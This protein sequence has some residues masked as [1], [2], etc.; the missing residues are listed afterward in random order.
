LR[1]IGY[2]LS[3]CNQNRVSFVV[4]EDAEVYVNGYY[5]IN[6]PLSPVGEFNPVL[7]R[8]HKIT[9]YNPEMTVGSFGPIAGKKGEKAYYGKKLE[10]LV[11][12]AEVLGY[13]SW[14]GK[15]RRLECSPNTWDSVYE[16]NQEELKGFFLKLSGRRLI[17]RTDFPVKIGR[18][19]GLDMPFYLDLNAIAKGHMFVAG[20][21]VEYNEPLIY[22]D[23]GRIRIE[24]IG[25]FVDRFFSDDSAEGSVRVDDIYVPSFDPETYEI[26]WKPVTEVIRHEYHSSLVKLTVETGRSITVTPDHSVFVLR[27]CR[28]LTV[29]ASEIKVGDYLVI[30]SKIPPAQHPIS[31]I[32]VSEILLKAGYEKGIYL[33][34][35]P[36]NVY[37]RFDSEGLWSREDV[38][39]RLSWRRKGILPLRYARFLT[40]EEK[41]KTVLTARRGIEFSTIIKLDGGFARLLGYYVAEGSAII[42]DERGYRV[43]FD[44]GYDDVDIVEDIRGIIG[45]LASKDRIK[46]L[47]KHSSYRVIVCDKVLAVLLKSLV[48]GRA[49]D[50]RVP[51]VILN[52]SPDVIM[53]FLKAWFAGDSGVTTS[54]W[55]ASDIQYLFLTRGVLASFYNQKVENGVLPGGRRYRSASWYSLKFPFPDLTKSERRFDNP[56]LIPV[57]CLPDILK[58]FS[59][60]SSRCRVTKKVLRRIN[61]LARYLKLVLEGKVQIKSET[62]TDGFYR[63]LQG[64]G[65][66]EKRDNLLVLTGKGHMLLEAINKLN[67]L[68]EGDLSFLRVTRIER[69][70]SNHKFVYDLSVPGCENFVAG[71]GGVFCHN[72]RSGKSTFVLNLMARSLEQEPKPRFIVFDRR[73]EYSLLTKYGAVMLPYFRFVPR[74]ELVS[75]ELVASRLG[76]DPRR[77]DGRLLCEALN[78][79]RAEGLELTVKNVLRKC[80]EI[81]PYLLSRGRD[82]VLAK[83][84]WV[85]DKRGSQLFGIE[86]KPL[87]IIDTVYRN[88]AVIVDFSVDANIED[89]QL[90]AKY[91]IRNV[92]HYAVEHRR[93]GDFAVIF[94]IEEAQ[95][96]I[97]ERGLKIEVGSPEKTGVDKQIIEAISQAGGYNVGFILVTQRPAYV[98]KS[99]ISQCNTI[100]AFRL[101]AGNDQEAIIKYS[102]YGSER[103]ADYL[104]GL[105][106]HEAL[107]WGMASPVPFPVTVEVDVRD[108][109]AKTSVVA[110]VAWERMGLVGRSTEDEVKEVA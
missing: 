98:S 11:A 51:W 65:F 38:P 37:E 102:E 71:F 45:R 54:K 95:Y 32:D 42:N 50:K 92:M 20:M 72:T 44:L 85:L 107:I 4:M 7:L 29:P 53:E 63:F 28:I 17:D 109:P 82:S 2:V 31:E 87:N 93:A 84:R 68:F 108:Y 89:Q 110:K 103:M 66:I 52:S 36:D 13:I 9:P 27:D 30:P 101:M 106:D 49:R 1:Q 55:L 34:N 69:V 58:N 18:H 81:S 12:W 3:G 80:I 104:P 86:H 88:P 70:K 6:H 43:V 67:K 76:L 46:V 41:I 57:S 60:Y 16:P 75:P 22:M 35:V 56:K 25:E 99:V 48:P 94:V 23:H 73:C 62:A 83:I 61:K 40:L 91:I 26:C 14:D 77:S 10:Y 97:P 5:F 64:S 100:A 74:A 8:V 90:A 33:H 79:I 59:Y 21:S 78:S 19:R 15:W 47:K 96:F 105:A 39:R 24:K